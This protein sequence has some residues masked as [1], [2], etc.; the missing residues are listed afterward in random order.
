MAP[1][2]R[3]G[4]WTIDFEDPE[5][6]RLALVDDGGS[7]EA[8]PWAG[9]PVPVEHQIRGLGPIT[10]SVPELKPT[11]HILTEGMGLRLERRYRAENGAAVSVYAMGRGGAAAEEHGGGRGRAGDRARAGAPRSRSADAHG[12]RLLGSPGG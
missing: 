4:R 1:T 12:A 2:E 7:G 8:Y 11:A 5:G 9:S 10:I 6:Q 3:D